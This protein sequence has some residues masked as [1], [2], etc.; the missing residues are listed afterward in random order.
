MP[1]AIIASELATAKVASGNPRSASG[2]VETGLT[3]IK[4]PRRL[5]RSEQREKFEQRQ[6]D[7]GVRHIMF[8]QPE[9]ENA[10]PFLAAI[11][12]PR[13]Q[14][15]VNFTL[16]IAQ[17]G[18]TLATRPDRPVTMTEMIQPVILCGGAGTRLWPRSRGTRAKQ[19]LSLVGDESLFRQ[20]L[21][22]TPAGD[23]FRRR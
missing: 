5:G 2:H 8:E 19:F 1:V 18:M 13:R 23:A 10:A 12:Q 9:H 14:L 4:M 22:R 16:I 7:H 21:G 6:P 20:T 17:S 11:L 3:G 15:S